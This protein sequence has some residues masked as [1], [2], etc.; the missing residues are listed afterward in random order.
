MYKVFMCPK[1]HGW[2]PFIWSL[3]YTKQHLN[4]SKVSFQRNN[5][6]N[7]NQFSIHPTVHSTYN[8]TSNR[9]GCGWIWIHLW[10][11]TYEFY[12]YFSFLPNWPKKV[13]HLWFSC[14]ICFSSC[15]WLYFSMFNFFFRFVVCT[16]IPM[17]KFPCAKNVKMR[18][19]LKCI[20]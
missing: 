1:Q 2:Y 13:H 20:K 5:N 3:Y 12:S 7:F 11:Y 15:L 6:H 18:D 17:H 10:G 9:I 4:I 14:Q 19:N 16:S 8:S